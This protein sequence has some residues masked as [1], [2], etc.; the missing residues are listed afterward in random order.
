MRRS[1][2]TSAPTYD[3]A[4]ATTLDFDTGAAGAAGPPLFLHWKRGAEVP[5]FVN[6]NAVAVDALLAFFEN[7]AT[8]PFAAPLSPA[9]AIQ[10]HQLIFDGNGR[11]ADNLAHLSATRACTASSPRALWAPALQIRT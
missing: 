7:G 10:L 8:I 5:P 11:Q 3:E 1:G 6:T 9:V 2:R 4:A